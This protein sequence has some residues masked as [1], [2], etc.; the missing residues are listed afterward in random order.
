MSLLEIESLLSKSAFDYDLNAE[1][2]YV[3][4]NEKYQIHNTQDGQDKTGLLSGEVIVRMEGRPGQYEKVQTIAGTNPPKHTRGVVLFVGKHRIPVFIPFIFSATSNSLTQSATNT[5]PNVP[6]E[7]VGQSYQQ[8]PVDI[9]TGAEYPQEALVNYIDYVKSVPEL[10]DIVGVRSASP[11]E[12]HWGTTNTVR[13]LVRMNIA[14]FNLRGKKLIIG[15][16]GIEKSGKFGEH[17]GEG[18]ATNRAA[19]V[20]AEDNTNIVANIKTYGVDKAI[21]ILKTFYDCGALY[22]IWDV[23][24]AKLTDVFVKAFGRGIFNPDHKLRNPRSDHSTHWHV[25]FLKGRG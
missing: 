19:D 17:Q 18:H 22:I 25:S 7:V 9:T 2:A 14:Y 3:E 13:A 21:E 4:D 20:Y 24:E 1:F 11:R 15:D 6:G 8:A 5:P 16:M 23:Y 12:E 10:R